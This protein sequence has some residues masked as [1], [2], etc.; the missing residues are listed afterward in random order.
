MTRNR[1]VLPR[2]KKGESIAINDSLAIFA[3]TMMKKTAL[4][5]GITGQDGYYL[6]RLLLDKG[7]KF[8]G[9]GVE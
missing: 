3:R 6:S 1:D 8:P 2:N 4:I 5:T 7:Y 9:A